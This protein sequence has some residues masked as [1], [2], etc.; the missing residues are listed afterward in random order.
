MRRTQGDRASSGTAEAGGLV[1]GRPTVSGNNSAP[2]PQKLLRAFE[3]ADLSGAEWLRLPAPGARCRVCGLSRTGLNEAHE[4]GDIR[5]ITV[6]QP[7]ATRGVKLINFAS[8][9][10]WLARLDA[11]QNRGAVSSPESE[12]AGDRGAEGGVR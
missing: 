4:R 10:G 12:A 3:A 9:R 6:R 7:G 11:E 1:F 5:G 8:L 2:V